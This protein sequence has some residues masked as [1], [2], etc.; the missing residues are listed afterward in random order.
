MSRVKQTS[1]TESK[2]SL[3]SMKLKQLSTI[4]SADQTAV[5]MEDYENEDDQSSVD[6]VV[7]CSRCEFR[8]ATV[9]TDEHGKTG[10]GVHLCSSCAELMYARAWRS[11]VWIRQ[12]K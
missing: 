7:K 9:F 4:S 12:M 6:S 8:L 3:S 2:A 11:D 1:E 5:M 10:E